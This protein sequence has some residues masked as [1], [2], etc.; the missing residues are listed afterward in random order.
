MALFCVARVS[1]SCAAQRTEI[2]VAGED[3]GLSDDERAAVMAADR[4]YADA[5]LANDADSVMA[6]LSQDAV[7]IPSGMDPIEGQERIRDFWF[8]P[9]S[10]PTTVRKYELVQAEVEG[11]A[12]LAYAR[13]SF[14]LAFDYDGES[15]EG[16]GT[17]LSLLRRDES[18]VWRIA[19]RTWNDHE[20]N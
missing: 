8:S 15:Y 6:T 9:D 2:D 14:T 4:A 13:G 19:R 3:T 17:Y 18:G 10:P 20:R 16:E 7:I 5:W 12:D 11:S 1:L